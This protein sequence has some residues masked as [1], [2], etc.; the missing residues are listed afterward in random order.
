M[1]SFNETVYRISII[2]VSEPSLPINEK[3]DAE[4]KLTLG[5]FLKK[6]TRWGRRTEQGSD[7]CSA[8]AINRAG[9]DAQEELPAFEWVFYY[10]FVS[11]FLRRSTIASASSSLRSPKKLCA[12]FFLSFNISTTAL[13]LLR[14]YLNEIRPFVDVTLAPENIPVLLQALESPSG[15]ASVD[16]KLY[17]KAQHL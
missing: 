5:Q 17:S 14:C 9:G 16:G 8:P 1:V 7:Q 2:S 10:S 15:V 6:W 12:I 4:S 11:A 3:A 13:R